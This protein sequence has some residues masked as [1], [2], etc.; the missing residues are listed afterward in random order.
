MTDIAYPFWSEAELAERREHSIELFVGSWGPELQDEYIKLKTRCAETVSELLTRTDNLRALRSD[1]AFFHRSGNRALLAPARFMTVP[2]LSED[3][4]KVI[5]RT[6]GPVETL[7]AFLGR[8]RFPWMAEDPPGEPTP[9]AIRRAVDVTAE[10]WTIQKQGT[11]QR[12]E[13]SR[14]QEEA[15]RARLAASGLTFVSPAEFGRRSQ[16]L[17]T[18]YVQS[19]GIVPANVRDLLGLG[20]FTTEQLVAGHKSDVPVLLPRGV[21]MTIE[22][23]VS[24]SATNS[25][26]RLIRETDG[27]RR[28]WR[29]QFGDGGVRTAAVISGVYSAKNLLDAQ[30]EGM[31]IFFDHD[32]GAL[33]AFLRSGG[34][35]RPARNGSR[36]R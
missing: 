8:E 11:S 35:P 5:A 33:D 2:Q 34:E 18:R 28:A 14:A 1:P 6:L 23:K 15:V 29:E 3:N 25:Y 24:N 19:L 30:S 9:E 20:E 10:L 36:Q 32:L 26:K 13:S 17:G 27:K 7:L 16:S 21:L 12:M 22:C 31:L 4:F